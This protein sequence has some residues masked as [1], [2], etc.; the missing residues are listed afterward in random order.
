[1][2]LPAI[3]IDQ[4]NWE[5]VREIL[6]RYIPSYEV[7]VFGSRATGKAKRY[8]DLDLAI[9][10]NEALPLDIRAELVEAFSESNLPWKVDVVDWNTTSDS[11]RKIINKDKVV[12]QTI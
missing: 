6:E 8:S 11:F 4:E 10:S 2:L 3:D 5:I 7:W 1:M 12:I 9:I